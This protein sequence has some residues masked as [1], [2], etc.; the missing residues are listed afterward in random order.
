M[1][2]HETMSRRYTG[3][4]A[5]AVDVQI[6]EEAVQRLETEPL[7]EAERDEQKLQVSG[8]WSDGTAAGG[9]MGRSQNSGD[10]GG[11][12]CSGRARGVGGTYPAAELFLAVGHGRGV[13]T[14]GAGGNVPAGSVERAKSVGAVQDGAEWEQGFIDYHCPNAVRILDFP[15]AGEHLSQV[16][17]ALYGEHTPQAQ[18]WLGNRLHQLKQEGPGPILAELG[19]LAQQHPQVAEIEANRSYLEKRQNQLN[20]P[21]F[22]A[23]GW[24]IGSGIV[25]SGNKLVVEARLKGAGMHWARAHV[26][27]ML[28][29]RNVLCSD[30]W[31]QEWPKIA[32]RLQHPY[33]PAS[34][35]L[36]PVSVLLDRPAPPASSVSVP[37][38]LDPK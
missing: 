30:R 20:Y 33:S 32:A 4:R 28:A 21:Q 29:L 22:R 13:S 35:P 3:E 10:W 19:Q 24:P 16:G 38:S 15:H 12:A 14:L 18:Q 5:G 9:R 17:Q 34:V 25:E 36:T 23:Q 7:L 1:E 31:R 37:Q 2:I 11:A 27:P 26:N 8:R 6:E